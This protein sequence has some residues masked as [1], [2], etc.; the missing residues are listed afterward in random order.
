MAAAGPGDLKSPMPGGPPLAHGW[1]RVLGFGAFLA[2]DVLAIGVLPLP[3]RVTAG[4]RSAVAP[5][6]GLIPDDPVVAAVLLA[7]AFV[8]TWGWLR[9][10]TSVPF[11]ATW[12]V[13]IVLTVRLFSEDAHT[14]VATAALP[15]ADRGGLV[16]G[17]HELTW[18]MAVY[19][20]T[21]W[22]G[23]V[24][25]RMPCVN[26]LTAWRRRARPADKRALLYLP[27]VDRAR[28]VSL[29]GLAREAGATAPEA[30]LLHT[31]L[32]APSLRRRARMVCLL[33]HGRWPG[34]PFARDNAP[35][36]AA[37]ILR[38]H[39]PTPSPGFA[40]EGEPGRRRARLGHSGRDESVADGALADSWRS[41]LGMPASEPGW[42]GLLDG[43]LLAAALTARG[44]AEAGERWAF[45]LGRW[46]ALNRGHR[47]EARH[48]FLGLSRARAPGWEHA[49]ATVIA[50]AHGWCDA[51]AEWQALRRPVLGA[52]G[53]GGRTQED[54][55]LVA[56]G[57]CWEALVG[58]TEAG[59]L[60]RRV[61]SSPRDPIAQALDGIAGALRADVRALRSPARRAAREASE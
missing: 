54:N 22:T 14:H 47:P 6:L 27:A 46:F 41:A 26:R 49:T 18:V 39:P 32:G 40:G 53:R 17:A 9:W 15:G 36:R 55:R 42:V 52:I 35:M 50:A 38:P 31:A 44:H 48:D 24:I 4:V 2:L 23:L 43:T 19:A 60:L 61:T 21:Y 45:V 16:L 12:W 33:A 30:E 3:E 5:G 28:A 58:D 51:A 11:I 34:D 1:A 20:M 8:C 29:W 59:R 7:A 56:A 37:L 57:R 10:G 25:Q 13:G